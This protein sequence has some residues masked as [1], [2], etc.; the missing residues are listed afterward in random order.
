MS[1]AEIFL[2]APDDAQARSAAEALFATIG[3]ELAGLLPCAA[4]VRHIGSTAIPGCLT[5]G[6]LDIVVRVG[7][8]DFAAA[9]Q[10]LEGRFARNLGSDRSAY[11][12]AFE[13]GGATPHLGIQLVV[14][15]SACDDF[16]PFSAALRADPALVVEYNRLKQARH[17]KPMDDY[18]RAKD[19]FITRVLDRAG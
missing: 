7:E 12:A 11:F 5:K 14:I 8:R 9:E 18:R 6:D 4:D 15:G 13:D 3:V 17:G 16:H 2:L 1:S 19:A 10:A